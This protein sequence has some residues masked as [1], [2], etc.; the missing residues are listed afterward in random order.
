MQTRRMI[1]AYTCLFLLSAATPIA[2][3]PGAAV[4]AGGTLTTPAL[5]PDGS[6]SSAAFSF[7]GDTN[8]GFY[9]S[10]ANANRIAV[11][12]TRNFVL[13]GATYGSGI[14]WGTAGDASSNEAVPALV[15]TD[16][17]TGLIS[18]S[19]DFEFVLNGDAFAG[20]KS[21][22]VASTY[23]GICLYDSNTAPCI[24]VSSAGN[25]YSYL[26][27][28]NLASWSGVFDLGDDGSIYST[29][30]VLQIASDTSIAAGSPFGDVQWSFFGSTYATT[31]AP[32]EVNNYNSTTN[33]M[34]MS[35]CS[36]APPPAGD[37]DADAERGRICIDSTNDRVYLCGGATRAWDYYTLI[38]DGTK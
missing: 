9:R 30:N 20:I 22:A 5:A 38:D 3:N 8:L 14:Y 28:I 37:C 11:S 21:S 32:G 19:R 15:G 13:L 18:A 33:F 29:N 23:G 4:F 1:F 7:D 27:S 2:L 36:S 17:D 16:S 24:N 26:S 10:G 6:N 12:D 35:E 31:F 34:Q 25:G